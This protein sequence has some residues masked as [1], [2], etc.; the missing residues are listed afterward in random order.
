MDVKPAAP[1]LLAVQREIIKRLSEIVP[2]ETP[3]VITHSEQTREIHAAVNAQTADGVNQDPRSTNAQQFFHQLSDF[4]ERSKFLNI[5]NNIEATNVQS[6]IAKLINLCKQHGQDPSSL[7]GKEKK[8][9]EAIEKN[10][11][12][13]F[14]SIISLLPSNPTLAK[15]KLQDPLTDQPINSYANFFDLTKPALDLF[16]NQLSSFDQ[17]SNFLNILNNIESNYV[18]D[19]VAKLINLCKQ[20]GQD[21]SL[22]NP[23]EKKIIEAIEKNFSEDFISIISL[24]PSADQTLAKLKLQDPLTGQAINSYAN[25]L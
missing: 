10:F 2:D 22:L 23:E 1:Q 25:F 18:Q 19:K 6:K 12:E 13:G 11:S 7:N 20:H 17:R 24:L 5:L 14:I 9:I 21:P 16:V 3:L 8:I 15:L 4:K